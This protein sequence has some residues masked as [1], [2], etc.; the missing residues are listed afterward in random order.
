MTPTERR[1]LLDHLA[2]S[3]Q[4]LLASV[5]N[6]TQI[7]WCFCESPGRWSIAQIIEHLLLFERTTFGTITQSLASRAQPRRVDESERTITDLA[8]ETI[9]E[10][11]IQQRYRTLSLFQPVSR[12]RPHELLAELNVAR[13]HTISFAAETELPLRD[14]TAPHVLLG[15][16]DCYQWLLV[17]SQHMLRHTLQIED[18]IANPAYPRP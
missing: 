8:I 11:R 16:L 13:R 12:S 4:R 6:L 18:V 17:M 7:Q 14:Y 9:A 5:R 3:H 10:S 1:Q 2:A 15:T